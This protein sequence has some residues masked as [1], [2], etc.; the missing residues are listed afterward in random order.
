MDKLRNIWQSQEVEEMKIS[1]EELRA[2]ASK[3][4]R[5]VRWRNLREQIACG[6]VAVWF[7]VMYIR[8]PATVARI[9]FGLIVAGAIY[10]AW[11]L[12]AR[13]TAKPVPSDLGGTSCA[14]F[15]RRQLEKQRDLLRNV[16]K[17]YLGPLV[18]GLALFTIWCIVIAR[19]ERRW[20][21][22]A[23]AAFAAL[24]FWGVGWLNLRAARRIER[25]IAELPR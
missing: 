9:S 22:E 8:V 6:A 18:P 25:T 10:V 20:Y 3:F 19:P 7:A 21:P 14:E 11:Q 13:G 24:F 1:I 5:E 12:H 17:W 2:K 16:W 4:Q 23:F 15:Y